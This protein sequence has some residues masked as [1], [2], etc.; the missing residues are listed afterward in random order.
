MLPH[1][2]SGGNG[3][4]E[5][6]TSIVNSRVSIVN[7]GYCD[8]EREEIGGQEMEKFTAKKGEGVGS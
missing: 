1:R 7:G 4:L 5:S 2:L 6:E 8:D 3:S